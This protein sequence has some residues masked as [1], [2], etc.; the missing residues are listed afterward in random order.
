MDI[1]EEL[2]KMK[3]QQMEKRENERKEIA[4]ETEKITK[5]IKALYDKLPDA[6]QG[7]YCFSEEE[8]A[9]M[10]GERKERLEQ[11]KQEDARVQD[12]RN[13]SELTYGD[14]ERFASI[15]PDW[16]QVFGEADVQTKRMLLASLIERIDVMDE[17][18][19]IKFRIRMGDFMRMN[20]DKKVHET[21]DSSTTPYTH[22][23][24]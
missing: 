6:I 20:G 22:D 13:R 23:L 10:I 12:T 11:L 7:T 18:I 21:I 24:A 4:K 1:T 8:L 9:K 3:E 14:L 16:K 2:Q 15:A 19:S 5:E 17:N